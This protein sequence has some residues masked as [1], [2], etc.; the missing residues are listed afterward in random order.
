MFE[1]IILLFMPFIK[2]DIKPNWFTHLEK[3]KSI[4]KEKYYNRDR[5]KLP[6]LTSASRKLND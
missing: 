1:N 6:H 4:Y 5:K 3:Y 2:I